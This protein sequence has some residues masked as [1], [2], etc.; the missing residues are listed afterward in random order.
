MAESALD[1]CGITINK[2][3]IPYDERKP[4]D[5]SGIRLGTPAL[6]TRGMGTAEMQSIGGW[7]LESLRAPD[8]ESLHTRIRGQVRELCQQFP[9]PAAAIKEE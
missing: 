3:M 9:V 5:P 1:G 2:N 6:T 8:D 7:I 4:V